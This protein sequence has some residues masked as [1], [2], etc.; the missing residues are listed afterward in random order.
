MSQKF[1]YRNLQHRRIHENP[2]IRAKKIQIRDNVPSEEPLIAQPSVSSIRNTSEGRKKT[3][4][5]QYVSFI[6]IES[7]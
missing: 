1:E 2:G 3:A 7:W 4:K 5:N 6:T